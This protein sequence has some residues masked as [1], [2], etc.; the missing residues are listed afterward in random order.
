MSGIFISYRREDSGAYAGRLHDVLVQHFGRDSVFFDIETIGL[1]QDFRQVIQQTWSSCKIVLVVIGKQWANVRD[2]TGKLRL[3]SETDLLRI[4]IASA[5]KSGLLIVPVLVGGAEM[6]EA[7]ALPPDIREI[8]FRN[9]LDVSDKRFHQDAQLLVD[10]IKKV[11]GSAQLNSTGQSASAGTESASIKPNSRST[12]RV[13]KPKTRLRQPSRLRQVPAPDDAEGGRAKTRKVRQTRSVAK[14][15]TLMA[16]E[17]SSEPSL[18]PVYGVIIGKTTLDELEVSG[19]GSRATLINEETGKPYL[20]IDVEG[21]GARFGYDERTEIVDAMHLIRGSK[22]PDPWQ[23]LGF[24]WS[25]SYDEWLSW[26]TGL[27]YSIE[28]DK[29]P[30]LEEVELVCSERLR[31]EEEAVPA[32][33]MVDLCKKGGNKN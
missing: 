16:N 24:D 23:T 6:P 26:L 29:Q 27:G 21:E 31:A 15:S 30:H 4:E 8:V 18:F 17:S 2:K 3:D 19:V 1:G 25:K 5:L 32:Q 11:L 7:T 33:N 13:V 20:S 9:A 10:A 12:P 22:A 28:V 14:T